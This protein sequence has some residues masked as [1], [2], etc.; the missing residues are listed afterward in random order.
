MNGNMNITRPD[1]SCFQDCQMKMKMEWRKAD[2][3]DASVHWIA[4]EIF[5]AQYTAFIQLKSTSD[6]P[7]TSE[8]A[9]V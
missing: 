9:V 5:P 4:I 3:V 7:E 2:L 1:C 6:A 8:C